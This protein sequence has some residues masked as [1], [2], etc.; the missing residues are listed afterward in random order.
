VDVGDAGSGAHSHAL[1]VG[2]IVRGG[3]TLRAGGNLTVVANEHRGGGSYCLPD[4]FAVAVIDV[5]AVT[6]PVMPVKRFSHWRETGVGVV[7]QQE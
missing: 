7:G 3:D 1:A 5:A 4:P 2:V 6:P